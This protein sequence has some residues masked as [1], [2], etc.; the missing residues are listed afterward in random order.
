VDSH[1]C[2]QEGEMS[3]CW[4]RRDTLN[5]RTALPGITPVS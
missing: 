3:L 2:T 4:L 1:D 5:V